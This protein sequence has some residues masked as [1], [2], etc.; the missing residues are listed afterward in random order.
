M[1]LVAFCPIC[2]STRFEIY[3]GRSRARCSNCRA[4][5]R[6]RILYAILNRE[7][8]LR[9][10]MGI[11][12][13]AP[14]AGL[15]RR[16]KSLAGRYVPAD[17]DVS[18]FASLFPETRRIDLC[19]FDVAEFGSFDLILH[20][21]VLSHLPCDPAHVLAKLVAMLSPAGVMYFSVPIRRDAY[22]LDDPTY[23]LKPEERKR[24][25][26]HE[27]HWRMFGDRDVERLLGER[28]PERLEIADLSAY[29]GAEEISRLGVP[30]A[31][32]RLNGDTIFRVRKRSQGISGKG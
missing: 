32:T 10:G 31:V 1:E 2:G 6:T 3:N 24:R 29:Y 14:E 12:H 7:G 23:T 22:T 30:Q 28:L 20:M 17:R 19:D 18:R 11:L 9:K 25:F 26:G 4:M 15:G 5:E 27:D 13:V 16:L 8:V 21:H